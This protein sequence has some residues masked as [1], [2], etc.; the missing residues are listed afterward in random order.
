MQSTPSPKRGVLMLRKETI[1]LDTMRRSHQASKQLLILVRL[2]DHLVIRQLGFS[3][4]NPESITKECPLDFDVLPTRLLIPT[5]LRPM[6]HLLVASRSILQPKHADGRRPERDGPNGF[7]AGKIPPLGHQGSSPGPPTLVR[8]SFRC[9]NRHGT[10]RS[11]SFP[12]F[13]NEHFGSVDPS[14]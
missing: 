1:A 3:E 9:K 14:F 5:H 2:L 13:L 12:P 11:L 4:A 8:V 10:P 7:H 6:R